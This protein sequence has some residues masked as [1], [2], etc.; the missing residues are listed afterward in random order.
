MTVELADCGELRDPARSMAK[1][2]E[3]EPLYAGLK[4]AKPATTSLSVRIALVVL[5]LAFL[6][7]IV[8]LQAH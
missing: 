4:D 3:V 6:F 7:W 1:P 8:W 2:D 5:F